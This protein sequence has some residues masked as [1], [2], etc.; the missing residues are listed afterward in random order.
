MHLIAWRHCDGSPKYL[1]RFRYKLHA[2]KKLSELLATVLPSMGRKGGALL[3]TRRRPGQSLVVMARFVGVSVPGE[4]RRAWQL[5]EAS[6]DSGLS[7]Q[8]QPLEPEKLPPAVAVAALRAARR[9]LLALLW[10]RALR[11]DVSSG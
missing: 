4:R 7:E 6:R 9:R 8:V 3:W 2:Q 10:A 5:V 11:S 1:H